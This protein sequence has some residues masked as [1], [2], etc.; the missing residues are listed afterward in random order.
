MKFDLTIEDY[1]II[2]NA[3]TITR[4]WKREDCFQVMMIRP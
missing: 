1:T 3:Y 2:L 4:R